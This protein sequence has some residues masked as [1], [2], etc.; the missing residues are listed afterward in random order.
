MVN[1][2][3]KEGLGWLR[4]TSDEPDHLSYMFVDKGGRPFHDSTFSAY[5]QKMLV[6]AGGPRVTPQHCR[7]IFVMERMSPNRA[8]GPG[9]LEAAAVMGHSVK[10]W[11]VAYHPTLMAQRCEQ[12]VQCMDT[13][14]ANML[15]SVSDPNAAGPS[16]FAASPVQ[17]APAQLP[18][19][20]PLAP[21]G[22]VR[23][24]LLT[25]QDIV[26]P[27]PPLASG[28]QPM[29]MDSNEQPAATSEPAAPSHAARQSHAPA[30]H[31]QPEAS[32]WTL[33]AGLSP[34]L[35]M[36]PGFSAPVAA[37]PQASASQAHAS[38]LLSMMHSSDDALEGHDAEDEIFVDIIEADEL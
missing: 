3:A 33:Q 6:K 14:R 35:S 9:N 32:F 28:E 24:A 36:M 5:F 17:A 16:T 26:V 8:P 2:H 37:L 27:G 4:L 30:T 22:T 7:H 25:A 12:P 34:L 20:P 23:A 1:L 21:A 10:Q 38:P 31:Q 11:E 13:W 19:L 18:S 29:D 15:A